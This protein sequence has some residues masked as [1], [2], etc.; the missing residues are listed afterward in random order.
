MVTRTALGRLGPAAAHRHQLRAGDHGRPAAAA[1]PAGAPAH[2]HATGTRLS[3][4][5]LLGPKIA[6]A[7]T[8][9]GHFASA[10]WWRHRGTLRGLRSRRLH[11]SVFC[12]VLAIVLLAKGMFYLQA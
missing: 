6:L 5:L 2:R 1:G 3:Y 12:H 4:G 9:F 11:L 8:A 10:M 7:L